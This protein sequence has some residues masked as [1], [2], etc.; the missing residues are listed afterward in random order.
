[1]HLEGD[2]LKA[3]EWFPNNFMKLNED[4]YHLMTLGAKRGNEITIKI[5]E[6]PIKESKEQNLRYKHLT[7]HY[8]LKHISR[9]FV[10]RPA[11]NFM[12]LALYPA[13]WRLKN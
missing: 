7:N 4:K 2:A 13:T 5:G 1:M 6:A 12:L 11:K 3:I 8:L 10:E 9:T